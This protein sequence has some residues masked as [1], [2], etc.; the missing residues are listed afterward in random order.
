MTYKYPRDAVEALFRTSSLEIREALFPTKTPRHL[1]HQLAEIAYHASFLTE[2][3]RPTR[4]QL[5]LLSR[6]RVI[7]GPGETDHEMTVLEFQETRP[8]T[9]V[10]IL[11]LAPATD[12]T[13]TLICVDAMGYIPGIAHRG[14]EIWGVVSPGTGS[15]KLLRLQ[16]DEA[17]HVPTCLVVSSTAPGHVQLAL[18]IRPLVI[19]RSGKVSIVPRA[20][21]GLPRPILELLEHGISSLTREVIGSDHGTMV[22]NVSLAQIVRNKY[23]EIFCKI[24]MHLSETRHG[25]TLLF[26]TQAALV[27]ANE[28][29]SIKYSTHCQRIGLLFRDYILEYLRSSPVAGDNAVLSRLDGLLSEALSAISAASAVDGALVI[30]D[31]FDVMGF[32][33]EIRANDVHVD[34]LYFSVG[35]AEGKYAP[36]PMTEFGTRHRS[37]ARFSKALQGTMAFVISQDGDRRIMTTVNG[38]VVVWSNVVW[39]RIWE[40]M[41]A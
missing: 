6:D 9:I 2:E 5:A 3:G 23:V 30:S 36:R 22:G 4:F 26:V 11:R 37:A 35:Q 25:L 17:V 14:L 38:N 41:I 40:S 10:E 21:H 31:R 29:L 27:S 7:T 20:V 16:V 13:T 39:D 24:L 18:N 19:L 1:V 15:M 12:F 33:A 28:I 8:L 34:N 32:S